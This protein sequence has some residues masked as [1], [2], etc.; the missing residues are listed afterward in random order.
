VS[1]AAVADQTIVVM[2]AASG[3]GRATA[4]LLG[5]RGARVACL[6]QDA[7]GAGETARSVD[8]AGGH[9]LSGRIEVAQPAL[10]PAVIRTPLVDRMPREQVEYMTSRIPM[11]RCGTL[12]EAAELISW[13]A[14]P[15]ARDITGFAF[16][17]SG[18]RATY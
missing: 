14:S 17:L 15:A 16:D 9:A 7:A 10:A 2:G 3:I 12:A 18:G 4:E 1:A 13:I 6:D 11:Q 5:E 8:A